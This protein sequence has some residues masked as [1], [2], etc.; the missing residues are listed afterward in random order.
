MT[1]EKTLLICALDITCAKLVMVPF[2]ASSVAVAMKLFQ[3]A[4][5]ERAAGAD[6]P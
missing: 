2:S 6:A 3:A 5:G 4:T 1:S